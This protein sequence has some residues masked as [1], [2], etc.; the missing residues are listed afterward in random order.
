M[1]MSTTFKIVIPARYGSSRLPGK[2]LRLLAGKPMLQHVHERAR[3]SGAQEI[4]IATDDERIAAVAAGFGA[5][6]CMTS[7]TH[8]SGTERLAEVVAVRGWGDEVIVVNLQGD[9]P[10]MSPSLVEKVA[11]DLDLHAAASITTLAYPLKAS[12]NEIDP[13]IVKV[14]VDRE[15]YALYFSRAPIPWHRDPR[16]TGSGLPGMNPMLH[17]IGLYAYRACFLRDYSRLEPSPLEVF[18]KLE[19]LRALWHGRKIHVGIAEAAPVPGVDTE[20]DLARVEA[21][22]PRSY[23]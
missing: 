7:A 23:G 20:A 22:L 13:N 11:V 14:V 6:V 12:E 8:T 3:A 2:P 4:V 1:P 16:E 5:N 17:H 21:M 9:E 18:E 19:Q 15:G 10:L